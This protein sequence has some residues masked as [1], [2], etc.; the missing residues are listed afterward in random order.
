MTRAFVCVC[1]C[2]WA[3]VREMDNYPPP[4]HEWSDLLALPLV[5]Q[6]FKYFFKTQL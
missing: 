3:C 4:W 2:V 6:L 5:L 1:V